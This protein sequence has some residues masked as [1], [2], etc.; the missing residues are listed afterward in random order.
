MLALQPAAKLLFQYSAAVCKI[1]YC[2]ERQA[3]VF[4]VCPDVFDIKE[5]AEDKAVKTEC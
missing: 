4:T 1:T 5:E 2:E 3:A